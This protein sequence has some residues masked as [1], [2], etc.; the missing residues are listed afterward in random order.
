MPIIPDNPDNPV[1]LVDTNIIILRRLIDESLLPGA[2][3][4]SAVTLAELSS[5][6]HEVGDASDA[7]EER[8]R[9]IELLQRT[10][11]E[12]DA[13]PFDSDAARIYGRISA[14]VISQGRKPRRRIADLMIAAIAAANHL[15]LYTTNA[16]DYKG[17]EKI[18]KIIP[19]KLPSSP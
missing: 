14:A 19:V 1:G 10:E 15:P 12:F 4:I 18:V 11:H 5:G 7:A 6:I 17:L 8:A 2:L 3:A 16:S 9:R 13:L